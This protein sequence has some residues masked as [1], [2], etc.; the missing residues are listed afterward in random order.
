MQIRALTNKRP[1][2]GPPAQLFLVVG[3]LGIGL[4][5]A[6]FHA[7]LSILGQVLRRTCLGISSPLCSLLPPTLC[8]PTPSYP[9]HSS[10]FFFLSCSPPVLSSS[11]PRL[12][13]SPRVVDGPCPPLDGPG[14][15]A[16]AINIDYPPAKCLESPRIRWACRSW[17]RSASAG[18]TATR[19]SS[20]CAGETPHN[21]QHTSP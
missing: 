17:T 1:R 7:R 21:H 5:S 9:L 8:S 14:T 2:L 15:T 19:C 13:E 20:R 6:Y 18:R 3:L 4:G 10:S 12:P 11:P 16:H